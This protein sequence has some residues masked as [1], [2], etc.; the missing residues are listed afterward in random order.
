MELPT[1]NR[2]IKEIRSCFLQTFG[3]TWCMNNNMSLEY[4]YTKDVSIKISLKCDPV[5][6]NYIWIA[7][8]EKLIGFLNSYD[9]IK[10]DELIYERNQELIK[11]K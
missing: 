9:K 10:V 5:Q 4:F 6:P 7:F 3:T 8:S 11:K 2:L 1:K